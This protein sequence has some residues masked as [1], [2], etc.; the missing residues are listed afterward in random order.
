LYVLWCWSRVTYLN[1]SLRLFDVGASETHNNRLLHADVLSGVNDTHGD[2]I[3]AHDTTEDVHQNALH[4][5]ISVQQLEGSL[6]LALRGASADV[7]EVGWV[8]SFQ[9]SGEE[10]VY[11]YDEKKKS[12][13]IGRHDIDTVAWYHDPQH[14]ITSHPFIHATYLDNIHSCHGE[15]STV[16]HA[17]DIA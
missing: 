2:H 17:A 12:N 6:Y 1:E 7:K 15:T 14:L 11:G 5:L 8:T 16:D 3:A 9:L 13:G 4:L 10:R